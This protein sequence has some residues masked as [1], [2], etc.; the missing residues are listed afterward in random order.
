MLNKDSQKMREIN[1]L[2]NISH[3]ERAGISIAKL[4]KYVQASSGFL[5]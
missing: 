1:D 2:N 3:E 5:N 4:N